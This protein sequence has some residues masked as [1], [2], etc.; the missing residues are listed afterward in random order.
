[1]SQAE[2]DAETAQGPTVTELWH[3]RAVALVKAHDAADDDFEPERDQDEIEWAMV[4]T[5][6]TFRYEVVHKLEAVLQYWFNFGPAP[7]CRDVLLLQSAICDL[8]FGSLK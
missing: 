5:P 4:R 6:S 8:S 7:D 3:R 2:A 1:M